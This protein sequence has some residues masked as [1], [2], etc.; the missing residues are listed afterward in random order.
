MRELQKQV[1]EWISRFEEGYWP[2]LDIPVTRAFFIQVRL[3][4]KNDLVKNAYYAFEV[5]S[6]ALTGRTPSCI[7]LCSVGGLA[8]LVRAHA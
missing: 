7:L 4:L 3:Y 2:P 5:G 1:D 6:S 8:Q